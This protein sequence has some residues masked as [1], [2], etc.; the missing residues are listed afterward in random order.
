MSIRSRWRRWRR[1]RRRAKSMTSVGGDLREF[2]YLD[3]VSVYSLLASRRGAIATEFT[4]TET[5]SLNAELGSSIGGGGAFGLAKAEVSGKVQSSS[6]SS[7]QVLRK[8]IVQSSFRDLRIG[9]EEHLALKPPRSGTVPTLRFVDDVLGGLSAAEFEGWIVDPEQLTRGTLIE[10]EVELE[11][12]PI[13]R[14]SAIVTTVREVMQENA[15]L[16]G[17]EHLAQ[18][19]DLRTVGRMLESLLSGLVPVRGRLVDFST[20]AVGG[21]ELLV[22]DSVLAASPSLAHF[23]ARPTFIVGVTERDRYWKDIRRVLFSGARYTVFA[24]IASGGV[25]DTWRPIKL[26]DMLAGVHP[27]FADVL[28]ELG[29]GVL[30]AMEDA[31]SGQTAAG[32]GGMGAHVVARYVHLLEQHHSVALDHDL[33]ANLLA[34][35]GSDEVLGSVDERRPRMRTLTDEFDRA[36]NVKTS[37]EV[38]VDLRTRSIAEAGLGYGGSLVPASSTD[39]LPDSLP[40]AD[41][42]VDTEIVAIYW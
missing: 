31:A 39:V 24:R 16:F 32:S 36:A 42:F 2:V 27:M 6:A 40:R 23:P 11:A 21:K 26:A 13:F 20:L 7:S 30:V 22:H 37:P 5:A 29:E 3:D 41:R 9:E 17:A 19:A 28:G 14:A 4:E 38:G 10:A 35:F 1:R 8:A 15:E 34:R 25:G 12:D 18:L 33:L